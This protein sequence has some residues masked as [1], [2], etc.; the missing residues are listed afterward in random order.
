MN[1][2]KIIPKCSLKVKRGGDLFRIKKSFVG[3]AVNGKE[4]RLNIAPIVELKL[5]SP[6]MR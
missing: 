2:W 1:L 4:L 5:D 6:L 3:N